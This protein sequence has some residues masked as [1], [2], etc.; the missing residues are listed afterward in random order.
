MKT[1]KYRVSLSYGQ[2]PDDN[3]IAFAWGVHTHLYAEPAYTTVPI[4]AEE[5]AAGINAFSTAKVAQSN[6]GKAATAEK[7]NRRADL[8]SL[9]QK[10]AYYVQVACDNDLPL[11]LNSGFQPNSTN[12]SQTQLPKPAL[13]RIVT[14][15]SG[16]ALVTITPDRNAHGNEIIVAEMDES[17]APGPFRPA[18]TRTSSRN[19][20][21]DALVPGKLYAFQGRAIGGVTGF[22]DWSDV[23]VQ[24]AA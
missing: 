1:T 7:N 21:I 22:S 3:M 6:G 15:M 19:I 12:R 20:P 8:S 18:V 23:V 13:V 5:L 10:L 14:R 9:L 16:Q 17:G 4:P 11:L 2:L 24:R